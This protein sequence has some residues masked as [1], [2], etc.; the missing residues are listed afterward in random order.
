MALRAVCARRLYR[1]QIVL[2]DVAGQILTIKNR[3]LKTIN[4][5][6]TLS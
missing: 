5:W 1:L 6:V 2:I 4:G 3:G